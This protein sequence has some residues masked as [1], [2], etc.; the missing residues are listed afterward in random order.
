MCLIIICAPHCVRAQA[1]RVILFTYMKHIEIGS[2]LIYISN[3]AQINILFT[4]LYFE[5]T[6]KSPFM[7][8]EKLKDPYKVTPFS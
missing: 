3:M 6:L 8:L 2:K 1:T 7:D 4:Y 5:I